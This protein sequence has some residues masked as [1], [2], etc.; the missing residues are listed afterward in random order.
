MVDDSGDTA[1]GAGDTAPRPAAP[2]GGWVYV[3]PY[4]HL[5]D[6]ELGNGYA[7][8][9]AAFLPDDTPLA[10]DGRAVL[11]MY[12]RPTAAGSAEA[13]AF[14]IRGELGRE[15]SDQDFRR[16]HRTIAFALL[17]GNPRAPAGTY[18]DNSGHVAWTSENAML[19]GHRI[20]P[21]GV[22]VSVHAGVRRNHTVSGQLGSLTGTVPLG[23]GVEVPLMAAAPD[24]YVTAL[25][26]QALST[27]TQRSRRIGQAIDWLVAAWENAEL[28]EDTRLSNL[29]SGF[30]ALL[31]DDDDE[32]S[33]AHP[34]RRA[35]CGLLDEPG[36][37]TTYTQ[38]VP[39]RVGGRVFEG[40]VSE[41]G[42]WIWDFVQLRNGIAHG[43]DIQA[44]EYLFNGASHFNRAETELRLAI[45]AS[46]AAEADC[47][48][49][50][51][52]DRFSRL[53]EFRTRDAIRSLDE[54]AVIDPSATT[55]DDA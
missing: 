53:L 46:I 22:F 8:L 49:L 41:R 7:I 32:Q 21:D 15:I 28:T 38:L 1:H 30:D 44:G 13:G 2:T 37:P 9:P 47:P 14:L 6:V 48:A 19:R 23:P 12:V 26:W 20:S 40:Q 10:A 29:H 50:R 43:Y 51:I 33:G 36:C 27:G 55:A 35:L 25:T 4:L 42:R 16:A 18:T 34:L 54:G 39:R 31:G 3:L 24:Q 52:P 45:L 5:R 17:E 11:E